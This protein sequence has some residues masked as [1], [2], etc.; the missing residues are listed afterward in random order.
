[1]TRGLRHA[2]ARLI[3]GGCRLALALWRERSASPTIE[4]ALVAP[5]MFSMLAGTYDITQVFLA[6]RQATSTAQEIVQIATEQAV[7]PDQSNA[8]TVDQAKQ[9]M[10]ALY[11]MIPGLKTGADT[12][13]YSVTLSA[14]VFVANA[15]CVPGGACTYAGSIMWSVALPP[16][17]L[18]VTRTPCGLVTQVGSDQQATI[19]N[20]PITG[21]STLSSV[22]VADVSYRYQ[23]LFSGFVTGP[24]T[25]QRTAF[26]PPRAGTPSQYVQY[27]KDNAST[28]PAVCH[29][30]PPNTDAKKENRGADLNNKGSVENENK[31]SK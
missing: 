30:A 7:Q 11:A 26:L 14:I 3:R 25:L 31:G 21:M 23:P 12:S 4:F 5:V 9:A 2:V 28:N 1:M 6:M 10:T 17:G 16:P 27:D 13:L 22:V 24:I 29:A 15:G 18:P 20:L 8:L 19:N